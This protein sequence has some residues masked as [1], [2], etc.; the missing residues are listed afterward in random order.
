[1]EQYQ[2]RDIFMGELKIANILKT[3][4]EEYF[5]ELKTTIVLSRSGCCIVQ[6]AK[7]EVAKKLKPR[8]IVVQLN[9]DRIVVDLKVGRLTRT[10]HALNGFLSRFMHQEE[11]DVHNMISEKLLA[12]QASLESL[13]L[14][15][16]LPSLETRNMHH[17]FKKAKLQ[18]DSLFHADDPHKD[19]NVTGDP[20]KTLFVARLH[21]RAFLVIKSGIFEEA[22]SVSESEGIMVRLITDK[23]T[24]KPRGYAFIESNSKLDQVDLN[25]RNQGLVRT[26]ALTGKGRSRD[27]ER[28]EISIGERS[29][30]RSHDKVRDRDP[31]EDRHH[32]RD[33]DRNRERERERDRERDHGRERDRGRDRERERDVGRDHERPRERERDRDR[34][35]DREGERL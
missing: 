12:S 9:K 16:I 3:S 22:K 21:V 8:T 35:R 17:Q 32:N 6:I 25:L 29:R 5:N 30:E 24:N 31:R 18:L 2:A 15:V 11:V 10:L 27:R 20:Y 34:N 28:I 13:N 23:E 7:A 26:E 14:S 1:M 33:R 19:P 4:F